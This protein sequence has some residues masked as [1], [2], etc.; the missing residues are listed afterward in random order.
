VEAK[1]PTIDYVNEDEKNEAIKKHT[2]KE[3][4]WMAALK[5]L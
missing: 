4:K 5:K 1:E 2:D 3:L